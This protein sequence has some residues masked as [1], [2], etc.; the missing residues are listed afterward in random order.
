M[1]MGWVSA[2]FSPTGPRRRHIASMEDQITGL[3]AE[4]ESI[5]GEVRNNIQS[6][7]SGARVLGTMSG[8][9]KLVSESNGVKPSQ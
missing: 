7:Q 9:L 5:H 3:K 1:H 8:M 4:A 6:L 2:I